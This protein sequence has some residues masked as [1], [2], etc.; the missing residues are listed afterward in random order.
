MVPSR[1][2]FSGRLSSSLGGGGR[3]QAALRLARGR[4]GEGK[5]EVV[6]LFVERGACTHGKCTLPLIPPVFVSLL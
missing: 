5:L 1:P 3:E 6:C 2:L 4:A